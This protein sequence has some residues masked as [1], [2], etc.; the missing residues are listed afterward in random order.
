MAERPEEFPRTM[1][2][3]LK[4]ALP[5]PSVDPSC[6]RCNDRMDLVATIQ[7]FCEH[8]GLRAYLCPKCGHAHSI[9]AA[10]K[11]PVR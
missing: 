3:M 5:P 11:G 7:P 2:S 8:P 4:A 9:L 10:A 6:A 1:E